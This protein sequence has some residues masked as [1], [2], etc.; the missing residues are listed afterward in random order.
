LD[1]GRLLLWNGRNHTAYREGSSC[2]DAAIDDY[3]VRGTLPSTG[4]SCD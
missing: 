4:A 2:I 3:L 1:N